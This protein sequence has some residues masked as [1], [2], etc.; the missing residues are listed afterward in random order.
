MAN[1]PAP[2]AAKASPAP[3]GPTPAQRAVSAEFERGPTERFERD[4]A[5]RRADDP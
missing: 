3:S 1:E 4:Q 5:T 2:A